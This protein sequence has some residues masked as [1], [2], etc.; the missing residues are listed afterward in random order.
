MPAGGPPWPTARSQWTSVTSSE[1]SSEGAE[2]V[3]RPTEMTRAP[4]RTSNGT[5]SRVIPPDTS[6][7]RG[8]PTR[9]TAFPTSSGEGL[10]SRIRSAPAARASSSSSRV[11]TSTS[12]GTPPCLAARTASRTLPATRKWLSLI[13]T[14]SDSEARWSEPPPAATASRSSDLRPGV[15][16]RVHRTSAGRAASTTLRVRVATP[17]RWPRKFMATRSARSTDRAGPSTTARVSP[18]RTASPSRTFHETSTAPNRSS[19]ATI[20]K[21]ACAVPVPARTP[22]AFARSSARHRAVSGTTEDVVTSPEGES[23]RSARS[24]ASRTPSSV[25]AIPIEC[26]RRS[27]RPPPAQVVPVPHRVGILWGVRL[28]PQRWKQNRS[29]REPVFR[30]QPGEALDRRLDAKPQTFVQT[31]RLPIPFREQEQVAVAARQAGLDRR[32]H[33]GRGHAPPAKAR[34]GH[35]MVEVPHPFQREQAGVSDPLPVEEPHVEPQPG[36]DEHPGG[37]IGHLV[38]QVLR[39]RRPELVQTFPVPIPERAIGPR[40]LQGLHAA[41]PARERQAVEHHHH[42]GIRSLAASPVLLEGGTSRRDIPEFHVFERRSGRVQR[43]GQIGPDGGGGETLG[44]LQ[45]GGVVRVPHQRVP[46]VGGHGAP[47]SAR[48]PLPQLDRG[49]P[50]SPD[51]IREAHDGRR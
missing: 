46:S 17:D 19:A 18:D 12:T 41:P 30:Q 2:W 8:S 40:D 22:S 37:S 15:V 11:S 9:V 21:A 29:R 50:E 7:L 38:E 14:A 47:G 3:I 35:H 33:G 28:A 27:G 5:E 51:E 45:D 26:G 10:S 16:L 4:A 36:R 13:R 32:R 44:R 6:S 1:R 31:M 48:R 42:V 34:H 43:R 23:S 49:V 25:G 20:S 24:T 39:L